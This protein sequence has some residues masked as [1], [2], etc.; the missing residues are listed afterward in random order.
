MSLGWKYLIEIA[1]LWVLV[2]TALVVGNGTRT[3]TAGSSRRSPVAHRA[4]AF[5]VLYL[6]MPKAGEHVEEFR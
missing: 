2:S 5:G 1:I 4:R 3:G 6:A